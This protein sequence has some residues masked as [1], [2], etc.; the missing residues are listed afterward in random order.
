M[1]SSEGAMIGQ[2]DATACVEVRREVDGDRL[3]VLL[4]PRRICE[5]GA[6]G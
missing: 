3:R 1:S 5:A 2:I 6:G 4:R